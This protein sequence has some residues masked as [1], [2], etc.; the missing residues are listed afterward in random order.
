MLWDP[1]NQILIWNSDV[2]FNQD[3]ILF[4]RNQQKI[5]GKKA[6]LEIDRDVVERPTHRTESAIRQIVKI[7]RDDTILAILKLVGGALVEL[8]DKAKSTRVEKGIV[9]KV[10]KVERDR[11]DLT[12]TPKAK[13]KNRPESAKSPTSKSF[14]PEEGEGDETSLKS[15]HKGESSKWTLDISCS[16][17]VD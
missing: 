11:V 5:V 13:G 2:V 7:D 16:T 12:K 10:N 9:D 17:S 6:S 3:S 8:K 15:Y 1:E 4:E 14:N